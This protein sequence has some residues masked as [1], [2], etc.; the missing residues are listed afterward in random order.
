MS[1]PMAQFDVFVN[2]M[3]AARASYPFVVQRQSDI[4]RDSLNQMVA[5]RVLSSSLSTVA[6]R[7]TPVVVLASAEYAVLVSALANVHS[8]DLARRAYSILAASGELLAA[9]DYPFFGV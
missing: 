4:T 7:L 6:G 8:R 9:I 1:D 3:A 2:P 5:P